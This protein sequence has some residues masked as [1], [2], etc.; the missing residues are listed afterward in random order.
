MARD[1]ERLSH[2]TMGGGLERPLPQGTLGRGS[3]RLALE[4]PGRG[5]QSISQGF[6]ENP[7]QEYSGEEPVG[8]WAGVQRRIPRA[9]YGDPE[10]SK[11]IVGYG[12]RPGST[13]RP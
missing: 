3:R 2:D 8:L 9:G 11:S 7:P 5:P 13:G 12:K 6:R 10:A 4:A 1:S